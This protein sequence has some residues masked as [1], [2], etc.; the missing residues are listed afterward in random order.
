METM[1]YKDRL[2]EQDTKKYLRLAACAEC[3]YSFK[4]IA[5]GESSELMCNWHG[6]YITGEQVK[7]QPCSEINECG[8]FIGSIK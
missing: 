6:D 5:K 4:D 7:V 8:C 3:P 2:T 1:M